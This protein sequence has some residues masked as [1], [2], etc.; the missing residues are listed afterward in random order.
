MSNPNYLVTRHEHFVSLLPVHSPN[1]DGF[2][3]FEAV[4]MDVLKDG[5]KH[6]V[7][8]IINVDYLYSNAVSFF[9]RCYKTLKEKGK[10]LI[11]IN[12]SGM[13]RSVLESVNLDKIISIFDNFEEFYQWQNRISASYSDE[14]N[15]NFDVSQ[16]QG[17]TIISIREQ[18]EGSSRKKLERDF[19]KIFDSIQNYQIIADL[20]EA[21]K[22]NTVTITAFLSFARAAKERRGRFIVVGVQQA[23]RELFQLLDIESDLEF[24]DNVDEAIDLF[25]T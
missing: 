11:I 13:V 8:D 7:L 19:E 25:W 22:V 4:F 20:T 16:K 14:Q 23:D 15:L 9:I 5:K 12:S 21:S 24:S 18:L 6:V 1:E 3:E 17:L 10:E 2:D